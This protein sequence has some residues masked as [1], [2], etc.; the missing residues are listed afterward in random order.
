MSI[1]ESTPLEYIVRI[2]KYSTIGSPLLILLHGHGGNERDLLLLP[3][4]YLDNWL[5]VSVR[6]AYNIGPNSYRWYDVKMFGGKI[7]INIE[8]EEMTRK[9]LI[10]LI[11]DISVKYMVDTN[12]I[13][14]AGFSQGANMAQSIGIGQPKLVSGFGVFSGR[15]IEE[16][17]PYVNKSDDLKNMKAFLSH[18][19]S[20]HMLPIT[21]AS[22]NKQ[23]LEKLGIQVTFSEDGNGH[24]I[25]SKQVNDFTEW[26]LSNYWKE[27]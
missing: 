26:L 2:P 4:H 24:S 17:I 12:R 20:D 5:V 9:K 10:G 19:T 21:Y 1:K 15:F 14:V 11:K 16:F 8:E 13:V 6:G 7:A 27:S 22:E 23:E 18:G 25:S 3:N